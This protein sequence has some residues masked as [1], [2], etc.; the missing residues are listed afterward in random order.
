MTRR[1]GGTVR[2]GMGSSTYE[3]VGTW[4]PKGLVGWMM[5]MRRV[6]RVGGITS[7][8]ESGSEVGKEEI[9]ISG[10]NEYVTLDR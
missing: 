1:K 7:C 5:G 2:V 8:S 6:R 4:V 9:G 10:E 3:F